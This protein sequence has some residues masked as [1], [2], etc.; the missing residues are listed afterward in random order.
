MPVVSAG[1]ILHRSRRGRREVFLVH[2]GGPYWAKKDEHAWS[3]PKGI[4][5]TGEEPLA[6]A[7]REFSEE[8]GFAANGAFRELGTFRLP[9]GKRLCIWTLA[10]N[11]DP[12]KL[13]SN[14]F[15][16]VWP[17]GKT[18]TFPEVDRGGWFGRAEAMTKI[19]K[20]RKQ[21]L[22]AFFQRFAR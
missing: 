21:I 8:T 4:V 13:K 20:G 14:T 3:V 16:L 17:S 12:A 15:E 22:D 5:A 11:C 2:P 1:I 19:V 6:A 18:Q 10:G 9:S 7:R